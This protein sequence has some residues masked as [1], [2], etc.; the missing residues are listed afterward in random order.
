MAASPAAISWN[1]Y[2]PPG[3]S[4]RPDFAVQPRL[5]G[6]V[7]ADVLHPD[8][9]ERIV[10]KGQVERAA[11]V[12]PD[13]VFEP[14]QPI[15]QCRAGAEVGRQLDAVDAAAELGSEQPGGPGQP[16][17]DVEHALAGRDMRPLE[18]LARG[19]QPA[20]VEVVQ[21]AQILGRQALPG[22][23]AGGAQGRQDSRLD[24]AGRVMCVQTGHECPSVA[25]GGEA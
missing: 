8:H 9:V 6:D 15:Q 18:Q 17:A 19:A 11:L 2:R 22:I 14:R 13:P 4:T 5:V 24:V 23:Q 12:K 7:H 16:G 1:A 3:L 20:G 21:R 25:A 10:G